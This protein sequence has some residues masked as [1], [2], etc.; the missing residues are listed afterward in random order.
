MLPVLP[1]GDIDSYLLE[2]M[3]NNVNSWF[4]VGCF[5]LGI[6]INI[7]FM[8]NNSTSNNRYLTNVGNETDNSNYRLSNILL[9]QILHNN[10][11]PTQP[12]TYVNFPINHFGHLN[13]EK[14]IRLVSILRSSFLADQYRFGTSLGKFYVKNTY[15]HPS[16]TP[17]MV[18]VV[19]SAEA[20]SGSGSN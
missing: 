4:I 11:N 16:I 18:G 3:V 7:L 19:L 15:R 14:Q 10:A 9:A 5:T 2:I 6:I 12:L 20:V 17:E 13:L 8:S 1:I